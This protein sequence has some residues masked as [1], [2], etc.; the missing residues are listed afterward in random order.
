M[1]SRGSI[2]T[3]GAFVALTFGALGAAP[4]HPQTVPVSQ[5]SYASKVQ[6]LLGK[7]CYKCHGPQLKPKAPNQRCIS[8]F[9]YE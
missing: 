6:P 8:F 4:L 5:D 2:F 3:A 7:Y 1:A 9:I